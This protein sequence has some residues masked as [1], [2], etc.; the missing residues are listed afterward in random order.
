MMLA[1]GV[2]R[3][4]RCSR[5]LHPVQAVERQLFGQA[6]Y[7]STPAPVRAAFCTQAGS[8]EQEDLKGKIAQVKEQIDELIA[9]K[10]NCRQDV[11]QAQKRHY[12]ELDNESKYAISKFAKEI[13]KVADNL[14]RAAESVK[15]EDLEQDANLKKM[16]AGVTRMQGIVKEALEEFGIKK[17]KALD[18]QFNPSQHEAMFA[19][20]MP[21]KDPNII[22]HVMEQGYKIH[23]R[24]LRAAK[25]GV[26]RE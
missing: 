23:D 24:T 11:Q 8:E 5:G 2:C 25:V 12:T 13:L 4:L 6:C 9:K 22:F 10:D 3:Q 14:E 21:G 19:M 26:T 15:A 20:P 18:E 7:R 17:M 1:R 16:H